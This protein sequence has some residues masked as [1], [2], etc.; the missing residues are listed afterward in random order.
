MTLVMG[1]FCERRCRLDEGQIGFCRAYH[2]SAGRVVERFPHRYASM[3]ISHIEAVPFYHFQ[4]GSRTFVLGGAGCNFD[5]HYC[6]NA[7]VARSEPEPLLIYE[8]PPDRLVALAKQDGCHNMAFAVNE[9]T[10]AWPTL[11][12]AAQAASRAGIPFGVLTNGYMQPEVAEEMGALCAFVNVSLKGFHDEFYRQ[13]VGLGGVEV[14]LRNIAK[15]RALTHIEISTPIIQGVNDNDITEIAAFIASLDRNI[16]WHVLRLLPEYKM[17][18]YERPPIQ[19]VHQ[20]LGAQRERLPY[21]YF[22]NFVGSRWVSTLCPACGNMAVER[23]NI[24]GCVTKPLGY[25]LRDGYHCS[26]CGKPL[27]FAGAPVT[28]NSEDAK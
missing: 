17:A 10:V 26:N 24:G 18:D 25:R 2:A 1:P 6:S 23:L 16:A 28:W 19:A 3:F 27:P 12:E 15:L 14:V 9:P 20:A 7:Y 5:C 21:I 8:I 4:P 11:R 13:H 22:G